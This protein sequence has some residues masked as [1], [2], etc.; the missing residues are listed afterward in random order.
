MPC[1]GGFGR[2][3]RGGQCPLLT[4]VLASL[5]AQPDH[6]A[7]KQRLG[8]LGLRAGVSGE[9]Q[10]PASNLTVEAPCRTTKWQ[11]YPQPVARVSQGQEGRPTAGHQDHC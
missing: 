1:Q 7:L 6:L 4:A 10:L 8:A 5:L 3:W 11:G 2:G 9:E